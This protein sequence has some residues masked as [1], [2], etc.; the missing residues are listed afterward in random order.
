MTEEA[1]QV[2]ADPAAP[3]QETVTPATEVTDTQAEASNEAAGEESAPSQEDSGSDPADEAK[4]K[5]QGGFQKKIDQLT[6]EKYLTANRIR[7]LEAENQRLKQPGQT[8]PKADKAAPAE[9]PEPQ[10]EQFSTVDEFKA[11]YREW[12]KNEGVLEGRK[13]AQTEYQQEQQLK[14]VQATKAAMDAKEAQARAKYR[15]FDEIVQ[16]FGSA[17]MGNPIISEYIAGEELGMEVAYHLAKNPAILEEL[18]G[19]S[20]FAAGRKL[21]ELEA[22][23][24]APP[25]TKPITQAP[26]PVKPTGVRETVKQSLAELASSDTAAYV[27]RRQKQELA[28]RKG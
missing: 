28:R 21:L 26:D 22:R 9:N 7:E 1:T 10:L 27:K 12:A 24:K 20:D 11:A 5:K 16:P 19:L 13:A 4:P 3:A 17:L 14:D 2:A 6:R 25:P 8:Q 18:A 23:L 15:D